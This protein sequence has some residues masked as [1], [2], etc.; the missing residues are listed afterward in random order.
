MHRLALALVALLTLTVAGP[1]ASLEQPQT[2][3]ASTTT[4]IVDGSPTVEDDLEDDEPTAQWLVVL[5]GILATVIAVVAL[6][7]VRGRRP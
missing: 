5:T 2:A 3:Q 7:I 6:A 1:A 4:T